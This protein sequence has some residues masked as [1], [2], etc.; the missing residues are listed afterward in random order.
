MST[1]AAVAFQPYCPLAFVTQVSQ[2]KF[3]PVDLTF[4]LFSSGDQVSFEF[5]QA[6]DPPRRALPGGED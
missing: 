3:E 2:G 5:V 4:G 1:R 6:K